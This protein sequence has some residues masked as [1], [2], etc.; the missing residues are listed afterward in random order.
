MKLILRIMLLLLFFYS[1]NLKSQ[2]NVGI[3]TIAP[4]ATSL[5]ELQAV[6]K[7]LL[8]PRVALTATNSNAPIGAGIANSLLV[9]NTTTAGV[10]PNNVT[11]GYYYWNGVNW[12][13]FMMGNGDAWITTGNNGTNPMNNFLG[14]IDNQ[15]LVFRTNNTERMRIVNDGRVAINN[16]T[17]SVSAQLDVSSNNKG[18]LIPRLALVSA[19]NSAPIGAG[20]DISMLVFNTATSGLAPNNVSPGYYYWSGSRWIRLTDYGVRK[21]SVIGTTD[22][23]TL[24]NN[25]PFFVIMPQM[26]ITFIPDNPTV[27]MFF[28]AAGT[29]TANYYANH[30][31]W[32]EVLV[33]G[34][35]VREWD[36][37]CGTSWNLWDIGVSTSLNVNV[38]LPNTIQIRWTA[39]R[40]GT[41]NTTINNLAATA[42]YF[43]RSLMILDTP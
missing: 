20:V 17:P 16:L 10:A 28:T 24:A 21:Y 4:N 26:T 34:V 15:S 41:I 5:L 30:S 12:V 11:P 19:D 8:I 31:V 7:G 40:A 29:Y 38:G 43:N 35:S 32:F 27:F 9:F 1:G 42:T 14:T 33:N 22:A 13:R 3:G 36:T 2:N 37:T 25:A 18:L 23:S 39:Q 6:D